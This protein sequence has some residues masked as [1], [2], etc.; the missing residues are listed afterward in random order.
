MT[1][2]PFQQKPRFST[3]NKVLT[4][5]AAIACAWLL[6]Q[7]FGGRDS[8]TVP[9][10]PPTAAITLPSLVEKFSSKLPSVQTCTAV[11]TECGDHT[12][13]KDWKDVDHAALGSTTGL[14]CTRVHQRFDTGA[15]YDM[16]DAT[17]QE[18]ATWFSLSIAA[19]IKFLRDCRQ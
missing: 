15:G 7:V 5:L 11:T 10:A 14:D 2:T 16:A 9:A 18:I 4:L 19:K 8:T 12:T 1:A 6:W 13:W 3:A 17:H